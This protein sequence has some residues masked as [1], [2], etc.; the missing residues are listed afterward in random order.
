[1][2]STLGSAGS[3]DHRSDSDDVSVTTATRSD[4]IR[5]SELLAWIAKRNGVAHTSD[6]RAAGFRDHEIAA[7]VT[8]ARLRRVR[9]S[10]LV[11]PECDAR[12]VAAASVGGRV[13]CV[14]AAAMRGLW[15]PHGSADRPDLA[16]THVAV[17]GTSSRHETAGLHM[18]WSVGPAPVGR[19]ANEDPLLNVLFHVAQCLPR[20]DALA[21]WESAIRQKLT[22][23]GVLRRV[24]W[25]RAEARAIADVASALSDSGVETRFVDGMRRAGVSVRQQVWLDGRPVDGLI[26]T[27]LVVQVDGFVHHS[28]AADRR[29]DI[30]ADARLV[31]RGFTVLRFDYQQVLFDW[32]LVLDTV[33]TAMAQ[34]A[35][36]RPVL[37]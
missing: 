22:D 11:T 36:T 37:V 3:A 23:P 18:H 5:R 13:T 33:L 34:G 24:A 26:G 1:M 7:A 35:H 32:P 12:R 15:V 14:S 28:T 9:R 4:A 17:A 16:V 19:N 8:S 25:R 21:I 20:L 31:A 27:S 6:A 10:W 29:R 30:A 2:P